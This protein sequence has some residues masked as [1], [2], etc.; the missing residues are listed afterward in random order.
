MHTV[1]NH[2]MIPYSRK[3]S[4]EKTFTN[5]RFY[6]HPRKF[7]PR[8]F[9]NATPMYAISYHSAKCSLP[10][11]P[12][13]FSPSKVSCYMVCQPHLIQLR[14]LVA[15]DIGQRTP[16]S[17][18]TRGSFSLPWGPAAPSGTPSFYLTLWC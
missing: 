1:Y 12:R 4:R 11:D 17:S 3:L 13:K 10:T 5:S 8:K 14:G 18:E 16:G 15:V 2:S 7:S 6:S 9:R